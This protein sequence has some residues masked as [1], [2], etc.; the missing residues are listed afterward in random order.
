MQ[1]LVLIHK[2]LYHKETLPEIFANYFIPKN[3][4]HGYSTRKENMLHLHS[5]SSTYGRRA[6]QFKGEYYGIVYHTHYKT[7]CRF[8]HLKLKLNNIYHLLR[9]DNLPYI[10]CC[11]MQLWWLSLIA[12]S[13]LCCYFLSFFYFSLCLFFCL[14]YMKI[15]HLLCIIGG[16]HW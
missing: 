13:H 2:I 12:C 6:I 4:I 7:K 15:K 1:I 14:S 3:L 11:I 5:I 10:Y 9:S 8:E 16:Q